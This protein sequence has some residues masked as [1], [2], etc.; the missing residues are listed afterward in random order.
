MGA[1]LRRHLGV[2]LRYVRWRHGSALEKRE[3]GVPGAADSAVA[4]ARAEN[5][6]FPVNT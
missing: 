4:G 2:A 6:A 5:G 3:R 1:T